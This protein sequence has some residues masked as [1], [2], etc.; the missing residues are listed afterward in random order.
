MG[1]EII[2]HAPADAKHGRVR[3]ATAINNRAI[4]NIFSFSYQRDLVVNH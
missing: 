1:L 2:E 4:S 3:P